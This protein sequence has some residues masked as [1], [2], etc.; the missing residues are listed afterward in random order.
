MR[1]FRQWNTWSKQVP[2][3]PKEEENAPRLGREHSYDQ[4][5]T[6]SSTPGAVTPGAASDKTPRRTPTA[7]S[8]APADLSMSP[9]AKLPAKNGATRHELKV[10]CDDA[11]DKPGPDDQQAPFPSAPECTPAKQP[12]IKY[13]FREPLSTG[14]IP[15]SEPHVI[16]VNGKIQACHDA[17]DEKCKL[18]DSHRNHITSRPNGLEEGVDAVRAGLSSRRNSVRVKR[19]REPSTGAAQQQPT[20]NKSQEEC[21]N[22]Q[23]LQ[24]SRQQWGASATVMWRTPWRCSDIVVPG[25][26]TLRLLHVAM[27]CQW[28]VQLAI[29]PDS[30]KCQDNGE[31]GVHSKLTDT[32]AEHKRRY[33]VQWLRCT[34]DHA[35]A[36]AM[37]LHQL[38]LLHRCHWEI[39]LQE[40]LGDIVFKEPRC[41]HW[42]IHCAI[43]ARGCLMS[44]MLRC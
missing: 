22:K 11:S 10:H 14:L 21:D 2:S 36:S 40:S 30:E 33:S 20:K 12:P 7:R 9:V 3:P 29:E 1:T 5:S 35:A 42:P 43:A 25:G 6:P 8:P 34:D 39:S 15:D 24:D 26:E 4:H 31:I 32:G 19:S 18:D 27:L 41:A 37:A 17:S 16:P 38:A 44:E 28:R 23:K 13:I